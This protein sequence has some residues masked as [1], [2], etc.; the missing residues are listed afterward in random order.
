MKL[1]FLFNYNASGNTTRYCGV[2]FYHSRKAVTHL[3]HVTQTQGD[4]NFRTTYDDSS[5]ANGTDVGSRNLSKFIESID[6]SR[7]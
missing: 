4:R 2:R 6:I 1:L 3:L 7:Q 5:S